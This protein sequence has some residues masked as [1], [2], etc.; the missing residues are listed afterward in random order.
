MTGENMLKTRECGFICVMRENEQN[1]K[2]KTPTQRHQ[3]GSINLTIYTH[4]CACRVCVCVCM[5]EIV[6]CVVA[7]HT[8]LRVVHLGP[9]ETSR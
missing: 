1:N 2:K 4:T 9:A 7:T 3:W 8:H 6:Q 5:R